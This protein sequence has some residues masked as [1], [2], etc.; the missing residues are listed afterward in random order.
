MSFAL[1]RL[2]QII[3]VT[4]D[5]PASRHLYGDV[6]GGESYYEGYSPYE[7][8]DASIFAIGS[9]TIEPMSPSDEPGAL[10]MPVGRFLQRFGPRWHS[11][12]VNA[13]GVPELADHL[14]GAGIR[15]VGPGGIPVSELSADGPISIYTHPKDAHLLIEF[16]DFGAP[17]M[18]ASPR[19]RPDYDPV[20]RAAEHPVGVVGLSHVTVVVTD[21]D[22]AVAMFTDVL[23]CPL[24]GRGDRDETARVRLG[25]ETVVELCRPGGGEP[26]EALAADG[27]GVYSVTLESIDL[28][29]AEAHLSSAGFAPVRRSP[30]SMVL[31]RAACAGARLE[32]VQT[33]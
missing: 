24:L 7:K 9:A 3:H 14:I 32:L 2:A 12:A 8:R 21:L 15:V 1:G 26:A 33:D 31:D 17:L 22:A 11:I 5:L 10:E 20:R 29:R 23:G 4:D 25:T 27:E 6:L 16:V 30:S 13:T 28:D 19:L 18:P